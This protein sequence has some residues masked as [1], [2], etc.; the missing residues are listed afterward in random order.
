MKCPKCG[1]NS[2]DY[3]DSCKKCGK[4]LVEFKQRFGIKSVLF[5]GAAAVVATALDEEG[6]EASELAA[7][8]ALSAAD[9]SAAAKVAEPAD[10][11]SSG[12]DFGFD[13]MGESSEEEDLSFDELFEEAP[14]EDDMEESLDAPKT[15][16]EAKAAEVD[17]S[18]FAFDVPEADDDLEDDF[19]FD[20][21]DAAPEDDEP[22]KPKGSAEGPSDPFDLPESSPVVGAP[23]TTIPASEVTTASA[24]VQEQ[25]AD[26]ESNLLVEGGIPESAA[27]EALSDA[28][29]RG[30]NTGWS[31]AEGAAAQGENDDELLP[32]ELPA[33]LGGRFASFVYDAAILLVIGLGFV[34][35]AELSMSRET[36]PLPTME[37][38]IDLSVPY[39]L[40]LFFLTFGYF[41]L[42]HFLA[43]QTPGKMLTSLQVETSGGEPL[44]FPQAFLRSVGGLLQLLPLGLGYLQLL[45]SG[46]GR[47]WNDRLAGTRVVKIAPKK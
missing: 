41:T 11:G 4:D 35:A 16:P 44:S 19:G 23:V 13:F 39:F 46:D 30:Q 27:A 6:A 28:S 29:D 42:F 21:E 5:P 24:A 25:W 14:Q 36:G 8:T 40:V 7:A 32:E 22:G 2:F 31:L 34:V 9:I 38:L 43:G 45:F 3:L 17:E 20:A 33:S 10:D 26:D 47:G 15:P 18:D 12:D 1:Y 37:T